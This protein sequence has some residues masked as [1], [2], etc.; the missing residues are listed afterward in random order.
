MMGDWYILSSYDGVV[1]RDVTLDK[2]PPQRL[3]IINS[4][5]DESI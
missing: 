2:M 1:G 3:R 4:N 5:Y